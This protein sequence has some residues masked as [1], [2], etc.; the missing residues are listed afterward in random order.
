MFSNR[1]LL[2]TSLNIFENIPFLFYRSILQ[3]D[4]LNFYELKSNI[5][6]LFFKTD[7]KPIKNSVNL[8]KK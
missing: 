2:K 3:T 7:I 1:Y 8:K 4:L 5:R 6:V